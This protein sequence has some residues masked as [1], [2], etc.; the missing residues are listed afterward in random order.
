MSEKSATTKRR[1]F[2]AAAEGFA[3]GGFAGAS[4]R[5]IAARADV[6]QALVHHH[7]GSKQA[8]YDLVVADAV[9]R[10]RTFAEGWLAEL[11]GQH[12][13]GLSCAQYVGWLTSD[14]RTTR[15]RRWMAVEELP[16]DRPFIEAA[17]ASGLDPTQQAWLSALVCSLE[18][19][20][21]QELAGGPGWS[22]LES[23]GAPVVAVSASLASWARAESVALV[24]IEAGR[25]V[26]G[27]G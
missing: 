3:A 8:L 11:L 5:T 12:D 4:M 27:S 26:A 18:A 6:S 7:F 15:L 25:R 24:P 19:A 21:D 22:E 13:A 14:L 1:V 20:G 2:A 17:A 23:C 9:E 10:C 16:L